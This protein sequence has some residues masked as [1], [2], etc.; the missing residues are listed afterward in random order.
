[1]DGNAEKYGIQDYMIR[2]STLEEVFITLGE[3][4]KKAEGENEQKSEE[5]K[6]FVPDIEEPTFGRLFK[7]NFNFQYTSVFWSGLV[8]S[9]I[10][11]ILLAGISVGMVYFSMINLNKPLNYSDMASIYDR[12][13]P[14]ELQ[15]NILA[16]TDPE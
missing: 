9:L 1:M 10:L 11:G 16:G 6:D 13:T 12:V 2:N 7:A 5:L 14:M 8:C 15:Y 3:L 4:E